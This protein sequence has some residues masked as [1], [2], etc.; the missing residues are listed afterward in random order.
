[1]TVT[2]RLSRLHLVQVRSTYA[3]NVNGQHLRP[4]PLKGPSRRTLQF[5]RPHEPKSTASEPQATIPT[6][7]LCRN[8]R[9]ASRMLRFQRPIGATIREGKVDQIA[10]QCASLSPFRAKAW[11][12]CLYHFSA[13]SVRAQR[14]VTF[15][16]I[17]C[18]AASA[19][20]SSYLLMRTFTGQDRTLCS[21]PSFVPIE[22]VAW[23]SRMFGA[24]SD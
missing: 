19:L 11:G 6:A 14:C 21:F 22:I 1:M 12:G 15:A 2:L 9:P 5:Q 24:L 20:Y 10:H 13:R 16:Y 17:Y 18:F 8:Q 3:Y 23:V 4:Q 7:D